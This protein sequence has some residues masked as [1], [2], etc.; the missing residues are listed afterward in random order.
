MSAPE[1]TTNSQFNPLDA[2]AAQTYA[3]LVEIEKHDSLQ[4]K[5]YNCLRKYDSTKWKIYNWLRKEDPNIILREHNTLRK[6]LSVAIHGSNKM[7]ADIISSQ[8]HLSNDIISQNFQAAK[9]ILD[10]LLLN[11]EQQLIN[12]LTHRP[13]DIRKDLSTFRNN[14]EKNITST[15]EMIVDLHEK[16]GYI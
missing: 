15:N 2:I 11:Q 9:E 1:N 12:Y 14:I 6:E 16:V 4:R 13:M 5:I 7:I 8:L 3:L 10:R